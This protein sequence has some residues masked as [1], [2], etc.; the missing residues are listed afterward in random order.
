MTN[1]SNARLNM[2]NGQLLTNGIHN[3][4]LIAAY[5]RTPRETLVDA[6]LAHRAYVDEDLNIP[7]TRRFVL[8]PLIEARML[9]IALSGPVART[10][11]LGATNV[12]M[13]SILASFAGAVTVIEPMAG[14]I[15]TAKNRLP[16]ASNITYVQAPCRDGSPA[17]APYDIIIAAGAMVHA[18]AVLTG[19]LAEGGRL[20]TVLRP[21]PS[22]CGKLTVVSR[23]ADGTLDTMSVADASTPYLTGFE[24]EI[25]FVF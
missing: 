13:L 21:T 20:V 2:V 4:D 1:F 3:D 6:A 16:D 8:E 15:E 17:G 22:G 10:L 5:L 11:V 25:S 18:P 14:L 9:Q 12:P 7:G 19:Q 23:L 24:P